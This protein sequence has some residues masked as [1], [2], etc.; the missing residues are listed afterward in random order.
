MGVRSD[1][2]WVVTLWHCVF[3]R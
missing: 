1:V 3:R 2:F